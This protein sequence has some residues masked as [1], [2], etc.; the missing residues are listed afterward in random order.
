VFALSIFSAY[1]QLNL[2]AVNA[3]S[4][5]Q[6]QSSFTYVTAMQWYLHTGCTALGS[7][8]K[9]LSA[10]LHFNSIFQDKPGL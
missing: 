9:F 10:Y 8:V 4:H 2:T 6:Y 5:Q 7:N 1:K 3:T